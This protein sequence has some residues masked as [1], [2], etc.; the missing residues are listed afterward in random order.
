VSPEVKKRLKALRPENYIGLAA[1][2]AT[3]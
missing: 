1:K 3:S 2:I